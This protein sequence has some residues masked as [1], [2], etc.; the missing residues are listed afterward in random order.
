MKFKIFQ[1]KNMRE[2]DYG[3]MGW[4]FA[5]SHGFKIADYKEV[6]SG[7]REYNIFSSRDFSVLL[8]DELYYEFNMEHPADFV[9]NSL[10]VS[11]VIALKK[12]GTDYWHWYYCDRFGWKEITE[13]ISVEEVNSVNK[14]EFTLD[15][16]INVL[17]DLI[18]E[19]G[20]TWSD[21]TAAI[22]YVSKITGLTYDDIYERSHNENV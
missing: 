18:K 11:D 13:M 5:S 22:K 15:D 9:G 20:K 1:L 12:D 14:F 4:D 21:S 17:R 10:S 7:E 3:F 2:T 16:L 6:Y 8:L 19:N